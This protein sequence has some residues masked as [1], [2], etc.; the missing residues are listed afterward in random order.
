MSTVSDVDTLIGYLQEGLYINNL[1][2]LIKLCRVIKF[3][4]HFVLPA[5]VLRTVFESLL[6]RMEVEH[7]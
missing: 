3:K 1:K 7:G 4:G 2:K 5:Y 6:Y